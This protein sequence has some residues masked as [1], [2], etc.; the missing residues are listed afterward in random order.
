MKFVAIMASTGNRADKVA[1]FATKAGA[2]AHVAVFISLY[3][4]AFVAPEPTEG[5]ASWFINTVAKTITIVP[6]PP[7][8]FNAIDEAHIEK[9]FNLSGTDRVELR[10]I[11]ELVKTMKTGDQTF[12]DDVIDVATFKELAW[13]L[14]R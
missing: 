8:D 4:D 14:L 2:D 5:L 9:A 1:W 12:F 11:F 13:K 7:P 6:P 3:P 10:L